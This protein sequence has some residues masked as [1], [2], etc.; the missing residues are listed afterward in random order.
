MDQIELDVTSREILGKKVRHLRRQ[1]ITPVHLFGHNVESAALQGETAQLHG[2]LARA[3]KTRIVNLRIDKAKKPRNVLVRE[4]QSDPI[5][6]ELLH[7]DFYQVSATEKIKVEVPIVLVGEAPALK[8]KENMLVQELTTLTVECLPAKIPASVEVDISP[9]SEP[10]QM[11]RVAD[12]ELDKE[13]TILSDPERV[14]AGI[15]FRPEEKVEEVVV[16][17]EEVV[18]EE[19]EAKAAPLPEEE[20]KEE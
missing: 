1:G 5:T 4:V 2:V 12:I 15:S 10:E 9:L 16:E 18:V 7:V 6:S 13:I 11:I 8:L 19:A 3:G 20:P 17:E 14:V